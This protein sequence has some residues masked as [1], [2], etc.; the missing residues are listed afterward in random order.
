MK[1]KIDTIVLPSIIPLFPLP[2]TTLLPRC[3]L[4]LNIFEPRYLKMVTNASN[5][6]GK[7][8]GMIQPLNNA[9]EGK[10]P[11]LYTTGC[12]GKIE[13]MEH[14]NDN[15]IEIML[16]GIT[17]FRI[18]SELDTTTP[19]RQATIDF[20]EYK[21]DLEAPEHNCNINRLDLLAGLSDYLDK[22]GLSADY[23]GIEG[24]PD[25]ILVNTLSMIIPFQPSE[26]QALVE[27]ESI[28]SRNKML[29]S[30]LKMATVTFD[31]SSNG[32]HH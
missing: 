30:L 28:Q 29:L 17:R 5:T 14:T 4:P 1:D 32:E 25:E 27:T 18:K 26:K 3:S 12:V 21:N 11:E 13:H 23:S 24:A 20:D 2:G 8:I 19:Y 16:R 7:L 15:R 31:P 6:P 10:K 9:L 22:R